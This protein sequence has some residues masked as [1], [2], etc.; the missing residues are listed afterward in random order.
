MVGGQYD[1]AEPPGAG[2][3][4]AQVAFKLLVFLSNQV[5]V[6]LVVELEEKY[7]KRK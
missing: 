4:L 3:A 6:V 7:K 2:V 5:Y 1:L